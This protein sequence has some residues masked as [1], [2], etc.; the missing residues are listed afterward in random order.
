MEAADKTRIDFFKRN[1]QENKNLIFA[2]LIPSIH[3]IP[4]SNFV[5][6]SNV[7]VNQVVP[8]GDKTVINNSQF[9]WKYKY[10]ISKKILQC[11]GTTS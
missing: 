3:F 5:Q 7:S 11:D 1:E 8:G 4:L 10:Q 6:I 2:K 9:Y